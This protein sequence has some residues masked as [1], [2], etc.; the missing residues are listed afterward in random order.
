MCGLGTLV[1]IFMWLLS[2]VVDYIDNFSLVLDCILWVVTPHSSILRFFERYEYISAWARRW[3]RSDWRMRRHHPPK[4]SRLRMRRESWNGHKRMERRSWWRRRRR[5]RSTKKVSRTLRI[6]IFFFSC[7]VVASVVIVVD[8]FK[9]E[10]KLQCVLCVNVQCS[11][12]SLCWCWYL[13]RYVRIFR[14]AFVL[15][16]L[17]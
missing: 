3:F 4:R 12:S 9:R 13:F 6:A 5:R 17:Q 2:G 8:S 16:S 10:R 1:W 14:S 11:H 15:T 7:F